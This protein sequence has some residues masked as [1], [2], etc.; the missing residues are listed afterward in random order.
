MKGWGSRNSE[1]EWTSYDEKVVLA[2]ANAMVVE[3]DGATLDVHLF[4]GLWFST[5]TYEHTTTDRAH[6]YSAAVIRE[7]AQ[8]RVVGRV[9]DGIIAKG[10]EASLLI[11]ATDLGGDPAARARELA[12]RDRLAVVLAA[13]G[14]AV[15]AASLPLAIL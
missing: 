5:V 1:G 2:S 14:A 6:R 13:L 4:G 15:V 8:V 9:K 11:F 12:A 10:G 7:G 3:R